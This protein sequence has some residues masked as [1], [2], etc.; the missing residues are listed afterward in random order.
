MKRESVTDALLREFLLGEVSD[1][2][3]ESIEE[4]FL[5]DSSIRERVLALEQDLTD[6]YL[7]DS[8]SDEEKKQF[9]SRYAQTDEQIRN[10]KISG[11]IKHWA[12][13]EAR[14]SRRPAP[15]ISL[16]SRFWTWLRIKPR[17]VVPIAVAIVIATVLAVVWLNNRSER[18]RHFAIEQQLAQLNSPA[19]LREVPPAMIQLSVRLGS[20]RS[21]EPQTELKI[22]A[23]TRLVEL[24]LPWTRN[25]H[26]A[27]YQAEIKR[28]D[29]E[30]F[31]IS[32][33]PVE[34]ERQNTIRLRLP[35][36][37]LTKGNFQIVLTGVAAN[38]SPG[39]S[40][41]YSF[42]VVN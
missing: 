36:E 4:L 15:T 40:E 35:A 14:A 23:G 25:E 18:R 20:V 11:A 3:R 13:E 7:D 29:R 10:I 2:D 42:V 9:L 8:L 19:N 12:I 32:D 33:L 5:T 37:L 28:A 21:V 26:Y 31:V 38:N 41:E 24:Q 34:S 39:W 6:D 17:F 27:R 22:P 30:S 16:W 1:E